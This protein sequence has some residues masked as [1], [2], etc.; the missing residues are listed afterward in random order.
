MT[1]AERDAIVSPATGLIIFCTDCGPVGQ[2][3]F[4]SGS[5]WYNMLGGAAAAAQ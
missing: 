4:R 5:T 3:Q 1:A 2:P